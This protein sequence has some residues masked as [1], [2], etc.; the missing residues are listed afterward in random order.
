METYYYI[1]YLECTLNEVY[2]DP[3]TIHICTAYGVAVDGTETSLG[4]LTVTKKTVGNYQVVYSGSTEYAYL[5]LEYAR[6]DTNY[7]DLTQELQQQ[8]NGIIQEQ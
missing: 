6:Q 3:A 1:G 4:T 8:K 2:A 7:R 5:R